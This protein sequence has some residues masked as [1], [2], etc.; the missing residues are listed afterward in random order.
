MTELSNKEL[1]PQSA[2]TTTHQVLEV[3]KTQTKA[4]VSMVFS[5]QINYEV[6]KN[7][8]IHLLLNSV[9]FSS[10][11]QSWPTLCKPMECSTPGFPVCYQ[12]PELAQTHIH[13]VSDAIQPSHPLSSP[14]L[15]LPSIFPSIRDFS[16]ESLLCIRWPKYWSSSF[17]ISPSSKYSGLISFRMEWLD[18]LAVSRVFSNTTVQKHHS[19]A[20]S[21]L[22][23]P[24]LTSIHDQWKNHSFD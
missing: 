23:S 10:V 17:S 16:K 22:Y 15:L 24:I 8:N 14:L 4:F 12:L 7:C 1:Y 18:L 5:L 13:R 19:S 2:D 3:S 11:A 21:F 20:L 6:G 9:Q